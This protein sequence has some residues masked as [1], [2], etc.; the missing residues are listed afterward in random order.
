MCS[1]RLSLRAESTT[2]T[3]SASESTAA[4]SPPAQDAGFLENFVVRGPR[5]GKRGPSARHSSRIS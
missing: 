5:Q 2:K 3:L 4:I 1:F